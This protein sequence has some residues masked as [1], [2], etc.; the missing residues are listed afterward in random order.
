MPG[1]QKALSKMR[2]VLY[3]RGQKCEDIE[4]L[5]QDAFVRLLEYGKA[6]L[7]FATRRPLL[8]TTVQHLAINMARIPD[9]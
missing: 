2:R 3:R 9:A 6:G 8:V 7:K 5:M 1:I 4:D